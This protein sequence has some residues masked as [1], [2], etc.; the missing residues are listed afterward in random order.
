M[1]DAMCQHLEA[2]HNL[3]KSYFPNIDAWYTKSY[4]DKGFMKK[5][6]EK[7]MDSM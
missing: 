2:L 3:M 7:P 1:C 4:M 6:Q 5:I